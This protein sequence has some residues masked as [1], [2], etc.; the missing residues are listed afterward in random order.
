[1]R[2]RVRKKAYGRGP[3]AGL[4]GGGLPEHGRFPGLRLTGMPA[5]LPTGTS[6]GSEH[7]TAYVHCLCVER[8]LTEVSFTKQCPLHQGLEASCIRMRW[9]SQIGRKYIFF[10]RHDNF[11]ENHKMWDPHGDRATHPIPSFVVVATQVCL[12]LPDAHWQSLA[13]SL[14]GRLR[15]SFCIGI[16]L[17]N[18]L[19]CPFL[20][21]FLA[22][23]TNM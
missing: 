5:M 17:I 4:A 14:G 12:C 20:R 19:V 15:P 9:R 16:T 13:Q 10:L 21:L 22:S 11:P 1:M 7:Q 2:C 23:C 3:G 6:V 8:P 18:R